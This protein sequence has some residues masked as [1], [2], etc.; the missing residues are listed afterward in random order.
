MARAQRAQHCQEEASTYAELASG[1][2]RDITNFVHK[3]LAERFAR[4]AEDLKRREDVGRSITEL[5]RRA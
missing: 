2:P 3:K 4:M 1:D 5:S